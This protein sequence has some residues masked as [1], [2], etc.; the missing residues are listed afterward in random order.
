M[1]AGLARTQALAGKRKEASEILRKLEALSEQRYVSPFEFA[2]MRFALG[3]TDVAFRW[4]NKACQDRSFELLWMRVDPR[5]DP[6]R[7]DK[8]FEAA[9]KQMGLG[10]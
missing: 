10:E 5:L 8:R 3:Q 1:Q 2:I 6:I 9:A 4:F 7:G